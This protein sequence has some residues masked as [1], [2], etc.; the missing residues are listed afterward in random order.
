MV[1]GINDGH[2]G[3]H[4][5]V[6][7]GPGMARF[8]RHQRWTAGITAGQ[9]FVMEPPALLVHPYVPGYQAER[10]APAAGRIAIVGRRIHIEPDV[11]HVGKIAAKFAQQLVS[12]AVGAIAGAFQHPA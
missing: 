8:L 11:I 3:E 6:C 10:Q 7:D 1:I 2:V 5:P 4:R 12:V 9:R